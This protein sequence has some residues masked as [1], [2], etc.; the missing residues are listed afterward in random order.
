MSTYRVQIDFSNAQGNLDLELYNAAGTVIAAS[1]GVKNW[2]LSR[3]PPRTLSRFSPGHRG[4]PSGNTLYKIGFHRDF[5]DDAKEQNDKPD[6]AWDMGTPAMP[7]TTNN[8]GR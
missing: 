6:T 8:L 3:S 5:P 4:Q 2:R 1:R 7:T